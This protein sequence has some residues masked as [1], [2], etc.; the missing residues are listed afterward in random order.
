MHAL[1]RMPLPIYKILFLTNLKKRECRHR[2]TC[3]HPYRTHTH[4]CF[5][6]RAAHTHYPHPRMH[7][8]HARSSGKEK[9]RR[10]GR[11]C[12]GDYESFKILT[13]YKP[14]TQNTWSMAARVAGFVKSVLSAGT[15]PS[16]AVWHASLLMAGKSSEYKSGL[17]LA[18][19]SSSQYSN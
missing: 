8:A 11:W 12:S 4:T 2:P 7:R 17:F 18:A 19:T 10:G 3:V 6:L 9:Q 15:S 5:R 14:G 16:D 1:P 13:P